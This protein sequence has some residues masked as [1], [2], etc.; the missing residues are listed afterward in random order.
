MQRTVLIVDDNV[1]VRRSL[2]W[3]I[4]RELEWQVCGEATNG[5]EG[6]SAAT[7]LKPD[8]VVLDLSMPVMNGIEAARQLK[9]LVPGSHLLMFTSFATPTLEEAA[10]DAGIEEFVPKNEGAVLLLQSLRR[11][12]STGPADLAH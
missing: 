6:V 8:I 2:R 3:T 10:R 7:R 1:H 4:E 9:Q 12:A 11:L 5:A